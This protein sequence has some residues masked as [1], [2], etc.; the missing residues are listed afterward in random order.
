MPL[1]SPGL[2]RDRAEGHTDEVGPRRDKLGLSLRRAHAAVKSLR[3][4]G[5]EASR[6]SA[7]GYG[8]D[9]PLESKTIQGGRDQN[10]RSEFNILEIGKK[11]INTPR[12]RTPVVTR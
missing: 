2:T 11:P 12:V 1:E 6:L 4:R 8:V 9:C 5:F 10:R 7:R 3:S